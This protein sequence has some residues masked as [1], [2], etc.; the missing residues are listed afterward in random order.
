MR[1]TVLLGYA[2]WWKLLRSTGL[3][4][5]F[6]FKRDTTKFGGLLS[7]GHRFISEQ[8]FGLGAFPLGFSDQP[9]GFVSQFLFRFRFAQIFCL[10][11][12]TRKHVRFFVCALLR[13][14]PLFCRFGLGA[15]LGF[16]TLAR[17]SIARGILLS[18]FFR[19]ST[20]FLFLC[21]AF[22]FDSRAICFAS[23]LFRYA[24]SILGLSERGK[25]QYRASEQQ[26]A[27]DFE[28]HTLPAYCKRKQPGARHQGARTHTHTVSV[29]FAAESG[30]LAE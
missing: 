26:A 1:E 2:F 25:D 23:E 3:V 20:R 21:R 6:L 19:E 10:P 9:P 17:L 11:A 5:C 28:H 7:R 22:L 29:Q 30:T 8:L 16:G 27:R 15:H 13:R 18:L 12:G 14:A 4:F 24:V